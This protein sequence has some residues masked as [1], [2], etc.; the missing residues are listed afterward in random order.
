MPP[1]RAVVIVCHTCMLWTQQLL[2]GE[3]RPCLCMIKGVGPMACLPWQY[4]AFMQ[5]V[6]L[7]ETAA[8]GKLICHTM[9]MKGIANE[10]P[11]WAKAP[12]QQ[13][14]AASFAQPSPWS[15]S[16]APHQG[17][18]PAA[19]AC[20]PECRQ[21][22][23]IASYRKNMILHSQNKASLT[24]ATTKGWMTGYCSSEV[25]AAGKS[26]PSTSCNGPDT[27]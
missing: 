1:S 20:A 18:S 27:H 7:A 12:H 11:S 4:V 14:A 24:L 23:L 3:C 17:G 15:V 6:V 19:H 16:A 21:I 26:K 8:V 22:N 10:G 13:C 25:W 9:Q 2:I 5:W